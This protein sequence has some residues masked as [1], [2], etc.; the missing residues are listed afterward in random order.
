[1]QM[2]ET[3]FSSNWLLWHASASA[4]AENVRLTGTYA[5]GLSV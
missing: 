3:V 4:R 1:M 2:S 5:F